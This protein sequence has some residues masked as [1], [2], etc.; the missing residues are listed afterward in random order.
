MFWSVLVWFRGSYG[1]VGYELTNGGLRLEEIFARDCE[2]HDGFA[3]FVL[4]ACIAVR[5]P[6]HYGA[7]FRGLMLSTT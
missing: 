1:I 3:G 2:V 4:G 7:V 5:W 6:S